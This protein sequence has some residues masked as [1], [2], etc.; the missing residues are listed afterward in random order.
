MKFVISGYYGFKNSGDDALLLAIVNQ[1]KNDY[2][3]AKIVVFS[4]SPKTTKREYG[5]NSVNRYNIFMILWHIAKADILISG[6]GT[7]I[8]DITSTKSLLYYLAIIK[9]AKLFK[10]K[11]MLYANGIGPL[12]SFK[13]IEKTKSILNEVDLI[14][15]RDKTSLTE[16]E[17]I[18]VTK[19]TVELT[20][21]PVFLLKSDENGD[22]IL[23]T[24]NIPKNKKLMCVSVRAWKENPKDFAQILADFCDYASEKYG[25]YTVFLPMQTT[26][27]YEISLKIKKSMKN[28]ATIIGGKYPFETLLSLISKMHLC[29]GMRLHSLIFSVSESVP[30]IGIVYDPKITGFLTDI[31]ED[32]FVDVKTISLDELKNHLD[33]L[34]EN[35]EYIKRRMKYE[36]PRIRKKSER[37]GELMKMLIDKDIK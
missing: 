17:Q 4:N 14:T 22:K 20:A 15:L 12:T 5:V 11:V 9:A 16:L 13:N 28:D 33:N 37:N 21:D 1:I 7:L 2:K 34:C 30:A 27:D 19:P 35:Y 26:I 23:E 32:R 6:G 36:I 10:K 3:D 31:S 8:Q 29:V 24:Y 18:E 25:I